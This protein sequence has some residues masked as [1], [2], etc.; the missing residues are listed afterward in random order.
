M[1]RTRTTRYV[2]LLSF[3]LALALTAALAACGSDEPSGV[4]GPDRTASIPTET[5]AS[6]SV[7]TDREALVALYNATDGEN[8][9]QS[10]NWLSDAPLGE[11]KGVLTDDRRVVVLYLGD[12]GLTG[13][14][15]P[16]LGSLS[17]LTALY[18]GDNGL[19]GEIPPELGSLS[20]LTDLSL[21]HNA[22]SGAIPAELGSL[23]N[24][25]GLDLRNNALSGAI[26]AELGSLSNL[27]NL[28]LLSND[29]SGCVPS[30]LEDQFTYSDLG[31]LSFC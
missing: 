31:D 3:V 16:E 15:P 11:W 14:I 1:T 2:T 22:L 25:A 23:S 28:R 21:Y 6:G 26:P 10:D 18:L 17:N 20:N 7:E 13:E 19:T 24:L 30:S 5:P 29:L 12:N 8:W 27:T 4:T 9:N